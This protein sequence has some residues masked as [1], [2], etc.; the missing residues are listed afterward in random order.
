MDT[1]VALLARELDQPEKYVQNV[2]DLLDDGSTVPFI[3][4]YRKE[5]HGAMDDTTLRK[6]ETRLKAEGLSGSVFPT[7]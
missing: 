7:K 5:L 3:A 4:R 1:I 6:L 2:V